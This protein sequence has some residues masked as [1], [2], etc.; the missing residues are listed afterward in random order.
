MLQLPLGD[1]NDGRRYQSEGVQRLVEIFI[2]KNFARERR[3]EPKRRIRFR[4]H[5]DE[6]SHRRQLFLDVKCLGERSTALQA[7]LNSRLAVRSRRGAGRFGELCRN[8][9]GDDNGR[10]LGR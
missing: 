1:H 2:G 4:V 3:H 8:G 10:M 7:H 6:Q 5:L 9:G